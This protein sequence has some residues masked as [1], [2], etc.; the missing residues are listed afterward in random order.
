V[1]F[2]SKIVLSV[3]FVYVL[4]VVTPGP[5]F[6]LVC[7]HALNSSRFLAFAVTLG[8]AV[9]ATIY[10]ALAMFGIGALINNYP[11]F[12]LIISLLGGAFLASIG[13]GGIIKSYKNNRANSFAS[14][15]ENN[16]ELNIASPNK[17][18]LSAFL[19]GCLT[20]LLNPKGITFFIALYG[21][22]VASASLS[23]K[24]LILSLG[25]LIELVWYGLVIAFVS[26]TKVRGLYTSYAFMFD[27]ILG[28]VLCLL[29]AS[30]F[31]RPLIIRGMYEPI[32][33]NISAILGELP[34]KFLELKVVFLKWLENATL[35]PLEPIFEWLLETTFKLTV[36]LYEWAETIS[37]L[38]W[39][40][41]F[42]VI[43][44]VGWKLYSAWRD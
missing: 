21:P 41:I 18:W 4:V 37:G 34:D 36:S 27:L 33:E 15:I 12:D 14:Y 26:Q 29:G 30:L 22:I 25:F 7:K 42:A 2:D 24:G 23:T 20:N 10:A 19:H 11:H 38:G 32:L 3:L 31:M 1:L 39:V 8:L 17:G 16:A 35:E 28:V 9:A 13:A 44:W 5:Y 43:V 40:I 6:V